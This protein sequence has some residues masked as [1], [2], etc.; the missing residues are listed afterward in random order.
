MSDTPRLNGY[1]DYA[2]CGAPVFEEFDCPATV[3]IV[4]GVTDER[5]WYWWD[6]LRFVLEHSRHIHIGT[7][8]AAVAT[9]RVES[10]RRLRVETDAAVPI[11][12]YPNGGAGDTT[13]REIA[14]LR[15]LG[16]TGEVTSRP[17]YATPR[18]WHAEPEGQCLSARFPYAPAMHEFV[19]VVSG[20]ERAKMAVRQSNRR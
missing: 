11:F 9:R 1:A 14:F 20:F 10:W 7:S 12:C 6:R 15:E 3:F 16:L 18:D 2:S 13:A 19:E 8:G 17:G 4:T 5:G